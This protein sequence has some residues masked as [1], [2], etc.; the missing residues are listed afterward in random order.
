MLIMMIMIMLMIITI[1]PPRDIMTIR[2]Y[3]NKH[4]P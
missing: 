1:I 4:L 2:S 3:G